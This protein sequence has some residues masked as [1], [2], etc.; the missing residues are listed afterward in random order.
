VWLLCRVI[1]IVTVL[2]RH[3]HGR[4]QILI[5]DD[6]IKICA[7]S[8][9]NPENLHPASPAWGNKNAN[10]RRV[11]D[12]VLALG[13]EDGEDDEADGGLTRS[14]ER[15]GCKKLIAQADG[16]ALCIWPDVLMF[17]DPSPEQGYFLLPCP[18][19]SAS[20]GMCVCALSKLRKF[21][22]A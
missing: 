10:K 2:R 6:F 18:G 13:D 21:M 17:L 14:A 7:S 16:P 20:C 1:V 9:G 19:H 12:D 8:G 5:D 22:A 15:E 4:E 3:G 11:G